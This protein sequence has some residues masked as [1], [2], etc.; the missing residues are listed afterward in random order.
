MASHQPIPSR[1]ALNA[2]R[3]VILT[4]S[5]SVILLAEERRRR[6]QIAR[7]AIDNARK[8]HSVQNYRGPVALAE[9]HGTWN[10]RFAEVDDDT[11]SLASLPRPRTSTRRRDR[12]QM[13]GLARQ[14]DSCEQES[15]PPQP[16]SRAESRDEH[17][18]PSR[19]THLLYNGLSMA[20]S[21]KS[22]LTSLRSNEP[23]SMGLKT[24]RKDPLSAVSNA[25]SIG[26]EVHIATAQINSNHAMAAGEPTR[27][28]WLEAAQQYLEKNAPCDRVSR[29]DY[30]RVMKILEKLV[31]EVEKSTTDEDL[32]SEKINAARSIFERIACLGPHHK[33]GEALNRQAI[34]LFRI[35]AH[36]RPEDITAT[37][38]SMLSSCIDP[39]RL[40]VPFFTILLNGDFGEARREVFLFLSHDS[41]LCSWTHGK[42]VH[43]LLGLLAQVQRSFNPVKQLYSEYQRFGL[44]SEIKVSKDIEY[45]IRRAMVILALAAEESD[46]AIAELRKLEEVDSDASLC[47][48]RLQRHI[49]TMKASNGKWDQV[50]PHIDMLRQKVDPQCVEFQYMLKKVTDLFVAQGRDRDKLEAFLRQAVKDLH[51]SLETPWVYAVLD[52]YASRR[53]TDSA[54]SWLRFCGENGFW[55][56]K[57]F[58]QGFVDRCR[59]YWS[60]SESAIRRFVKLLCGHGLVSKQFSDLVSGTTS[61]HHVDP[62]SSLREVVLEQ[63]RHEPPNL[64]RAR[65]LIAQAHKEGRDTADA[66]PALLIAQFEQGD[67]PRELIHNALQSGFCLHDSVYNKAAQA[68][69]GM[70]NHKAAAEICE[71]AARE[72]GNGQLLYCE[73]NFSN[74]VYAYTG[75]ANYAALQSVLSEFTSEAQWWHGS[76][77]CKET[78]KLAMKAVAMRTVADEKKSELHRRALEHLDI[79]LLHVKEC[80]PTT[81]ERLAVVEACVHVTKAPRPKAIRRTY[82]RFCKK[83][84]D[85]AR[86]GCAAASLDDVQTPVD[87]PVP[88]AA[89]R[90][91]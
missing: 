52:E 13:T 8:L 9:C 35:V 7:A 83:S 6:L 44:F 38:S 26:N 34:R 87:H 37:L 60:F 55:M 43:R 36:S 47:D 85:A 57:V 88:A 21:S 56:G 18:E 1:A 17:T 45:Q 30:Q 23:Q 63:L 39:A 3:G 11:L 65:Q 31:T 40:L 33:A 68:L 24:H 29:R 79:A 66:L 4:T 20:S 5:C 69:S 19:A 58:N 74:L 90:S 82:H 86:H 80:R 75:S 32:R 54:I 84:G 59:K 2:L 10:G 28:N 71:V 62:S 51:L 42:S 14:T 73:Y 61:D 78:I 15:R 27:K 12:T 25:N 53:Q 81:D 64:E 89:S 16:V 70:G 41:T 48:I 22:N 91:A 49:V 46:F 77:M 50:W 67:D 76:P 72:N